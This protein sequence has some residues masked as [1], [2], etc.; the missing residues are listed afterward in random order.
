MAQSWTNHRRSLRKYSGSQRTCT[1]VR[2]RSLKRGLAPFRTAG[3]LYEP[4]GGAATRKRAPAVRTI[5]RMQRMFLQR[6]SGLPRTGNSARRGNAP[7]TRGRREAS[8]TV[9]MML[10]GLSRIC[11]LTRATV[12]TFIGPTWLGRYMRQAAA[13]QKNKSEMKFLMPATFRKKD[14]F[15]AGSIMRKEPRSKRSGR[16]SDPAS[17]E[18]AARHNLDTARRRNAC[19]TRP[20]HSGGQELT[21][22]ISMTASPRHYSEYQRHTARPRYEDERPRIERLKKR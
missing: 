8:V 10:F 20:V 15:S 13:S 21:R 18:Y 7:G 11:M 19:R 12:A 4:K 9:Q 2:R 6:R 16:Y 17:A 3:R 22:L 1:S 14:E 5:A